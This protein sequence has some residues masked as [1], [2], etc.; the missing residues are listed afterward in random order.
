MVVSNNRISTPLLK[1]DFDD[2]FAEQLIS[3]DLSNNQIPSIDSNLFFKSD[4]TSR[5][6][7]LNYLNLGYNHIST[8]DMLLALTIPNSNLNFL[9]N[10]NPIYTLVNQLNLPYTDSRFA[11]AGVG[12]RVINVTSNVLA[13][14]SDS[15]L[16][17][18]G[19][20][21]QKDLKHFLNKIANYD[22]RQALNTVQLT[23]KMCF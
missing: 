20:N 8:F 23:I 6:K 17:Q 18:Y 11:Y 15:N 7:T 12:N 3:I 5:F 1:S 19:L 9:V 10:S 21:N 14:F 4:G 16:L 13:T 2:K 22:L